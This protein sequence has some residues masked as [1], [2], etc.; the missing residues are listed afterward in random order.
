MVFIKN[1][2]TH[3]PICNFE[4]LKGPC[5]AEPALKIGKYYRWQKLLAVKSFGLKKNSSF[6]HMI[7]NAEIFS[8]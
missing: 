7:K 3:R 4:G 1:V 8:L 5:S 6:G 2:L